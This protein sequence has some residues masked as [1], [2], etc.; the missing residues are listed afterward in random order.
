MMVAATVAATAGEAMVAVAMA[1]AVAGEVGTASAAMAG[2][3]RAQG[4]M[5]ERGERDL[6][7]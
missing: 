3:A 4:G 6:T 5:A 2:A 1:M 7:V